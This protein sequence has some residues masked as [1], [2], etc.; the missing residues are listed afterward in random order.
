MLRFLVKAGHF[1]YVPGVELP[2]TEHREIPLYEGDIDEDLK[3]I[4]NDTIA[5]GISGALSNPGKMPEKAL[6]ISAFRRRTG[7]ILAE[8]EGTVCSDCYA[9]KRRFKHPKVQQKLE[10]RFE[11]LHHPLWVPAMI[12]LIR[13]QVSR[14]FRWLDS[15]DL[16]SLSMLKNIVTV[17]EHTRHIL[18]WLPTKEAGILSSIDVPIPE[19][20]VIRLSG[21]MV[22]GL[23]PT[24]WPLTSTVVSG[25]DEPVRD[26]SIRCEATL[27]GNRCGDCRACWGSTPN[28]EYV[29]H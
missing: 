20:L 27:R 28:I 18:H 21:T 8:Q 4:T 29:K 14:Y 9:R 24:L 19:N 13:M 22:D 17:C 10:S 2:L 12:H 26:G 1:R 25:R 15:G 7:S 6:G 16:Q 5:E 11:G 3:L 23:P